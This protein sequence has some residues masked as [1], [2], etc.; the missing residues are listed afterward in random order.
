M[1]IKQFNDAIY[2]E[3]SMPIELLRATLTNQ[4][5]KKDFKTS[6]RFYTIGKN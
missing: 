1:T 6:W 2:S 4:P 3:G 5:I